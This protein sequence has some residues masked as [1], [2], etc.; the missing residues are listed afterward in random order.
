MIK[1]TMQLC[2]V[3]L[4]AN[5]DLGQCQVENTSWQPALVAITGLAEYAGIRATFE[6][7]WKLFMKHR[8][9]IVGMRRAGAAA[10]SAFCKLSG[11][12]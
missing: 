10:S 7:T 12:P 1:T 3:T 6:I 2:M 9:L 8:D 11:T 5:I 4:I